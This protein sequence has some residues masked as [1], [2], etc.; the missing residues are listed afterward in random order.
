VDLKL[1]D[2]AVLVTGSTAGIGFAIARSLATE[3]AHVYVNGRT[4]ER[5]DAAVAAI[6]SRAASIKV[7]GIVANFSSSAGAEAVIAKLRQW[8]CW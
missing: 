2:K 8:M 4:R 5:V 7:N 1:T 3:G 6:R